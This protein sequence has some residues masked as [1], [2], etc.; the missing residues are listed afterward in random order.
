[1]GNGFLRVFAAVAL[2]AGTPA[3]AADGIKVGVVVAESGYLAVVDQGGRDGFKLA[4][5]QVNATGGVGGKTLE[6]AIADGKAE[7]QETVNAYRKVIDSGALFMLNGS[8]SAGNAGG[9]PVAARAKVPVLMFG[10]LP[11]D[12]KSLPWMFTTLPPQKFDADQRLRAVRD[13]ARVTEIGI[14]T[15]PSP[16]AK[17]M[18]DLLQKNAANFGIKVVAHETYRPTDADFSV[19]VAKMQSQGAKAILKVGVGPSTLSTAKALK[20]LGS[21]IPLIA[22]ETDWVVARAVAD[23]LGSNFIMVVFPASIYRELPQAHPFRKNASEFMKLWVGKYGDRD[24]T[25]GMLGWDAVSVAVAALKKAGTGDGQKLRD[26][27]ESLQNF[28]GITTTYTFSK[29][30]HFGP[31]KNPYL[32]VQILDG[33]MKFLD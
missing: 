21:S 30:N 23:L 7:P 17:Q 26:A 6:L 33:K 28:Q 1:M 11:N 5:D 25:W 16:Y 24:P 4:V 27:I 8:S 10:N 13:V 14:L 9:G 2:V 12:P 3:V 31:S 18:D 32:V 20:Q 29:E 22:N 19:P 15:D